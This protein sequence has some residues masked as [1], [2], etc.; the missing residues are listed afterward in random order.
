MF[1]AVRNPVFLT[2]HRRRVDCELLT[3]RIVCSSCLHFNCV[4]AV[5]Q[6]CQTEAPE[7]AQ[8]VNFI[9]QV[10]VPLSRQSE[11]RASKEIELHCEFDCKRTISHC[12]ELMSSK[13]VRGIAA[14]VFDRYNFAL[15]DCLHLPQRMIAGFFPSLVVVHWNEDGVFEQF[16]PLIAFGWRNAE[17]RIT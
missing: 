11:N 17:Q 4:V 10:L 12:D 3:L 1:V 14:K 15:R 2:E 6:F 16:K 7:N 13:D 8:V 5:P 9:E